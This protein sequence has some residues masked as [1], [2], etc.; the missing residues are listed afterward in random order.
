MTNRKL[1]KKYVD[2]DYELLEVEGLV[3]TYQDKEKKEPFTIDFE[4]LCPVVIDKLENGFIPNKVLLA[5][6]NIRESNYYYLKA[7][8]TEKQFP[9]AT[10]I[11]FYLLCLELLETEQKLKPKLALFYETITDTEKYYHALKYSGIT[12]QTLSNYRKYETAEDFL[13]IKFKPEKLQDIL[14]YVAKVEEQS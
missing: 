3:Y 11:R 6:Y 9:K 7:G 12:R 5:K 4:K 2:D 1:N 8:N 14:D 10:P 13:K